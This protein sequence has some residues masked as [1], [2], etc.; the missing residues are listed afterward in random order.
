M[1]NPNVKSFKEKIFKDLSDGK[2]YKCYGGY[3]AEITSSVYFY[4]LDMFFRMKPQT[5]NACTLDWLLLSI[6]NNCIKILKVN[7]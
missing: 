2:I 4:E 6:S 7:L 3:D 1:S 5:K